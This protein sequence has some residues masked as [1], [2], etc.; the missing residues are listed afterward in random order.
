MRDLYFLIHSVW[1][2]LLILGAL[3]VIRLWTY[4]GPRKW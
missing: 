4:R 1:I 3:G 2:L